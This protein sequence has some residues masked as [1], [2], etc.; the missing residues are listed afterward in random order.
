M[1]VHGDKQWTVRIGIF[2]ACCA[3]AGVGIA[4]WI[5]H[6][7]QSARR[8]AHAAR[9]ARDAAAAQKQ[10]LKQA[11]LVHMREGD[12][13][14]AET[15]LAQL[16][17][18]DAMFEPG[19]V[20]SA[21]QAIAREIPN[22]R[23][24]RDAE[25]RIVDGQLGLAEKALSQVSENTALFK[26]RTE[27]WG[28]LDQAIAERMNHARTLLGQTSNLTAMKLLV[29][30]MDDLLVVKPSHRDALAYKQVAAAAIERMGAGLDRLSPPDQVRE[31]FRLGE[32][33]A[34]SQKAE[35]CA[36]TNRECAKL[37]KQVSDFSHRFGT[38][39]A[40]EPSEWAALFAL[41]QTISGDSPSLTV[42][43]VRKAAVAQQLKRAAAARA[44]G[45]MRQARVAASQVL[46]LEP[47]N[48]QALA[49]LRELRE[50]A[51]QFFL[52]HVD[53]AT[54]EDLEKRYRAVIDMTPP[55]D[56]Y[57]QK[58]KVQLARLKKKQ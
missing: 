46:V 52:T 49:I 39:G 42:V 33:E 43:Y 18:T 1:A 44:A 51:R 30:T 56:E 8:E 54:P 26:Q 23:H 3:V 27:A 55:E 14:Q 32:F 12:F 25:A 41:A 9:A 15:A 5:N 24:L 29:T 16:L 13:E 17:G 38:E 28:R 36:K 11:V 31:H 57:H 22:Q 21:Q 37:A 50:A 2:A 58:A 45:E 53:G 48:P 34:A 6:H 4:G 40:K 7:Q 20:A 10:Q 35:A 19:W 47:K